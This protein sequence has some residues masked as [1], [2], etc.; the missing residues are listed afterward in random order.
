VLLEK[1]AQ[2]SQG[3]NL[4]EAD[5]ILPSGTKIGPIEVKSSGYK[6]YKSLDLSCEKFSSRVNKR[7]LVYTKD[8]R[9]DESITYLPVDMVQ[10]L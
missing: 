4:Y 8:L 6:T 3:I 10:L 7:Y 5:F 1:P 2:L 9:R